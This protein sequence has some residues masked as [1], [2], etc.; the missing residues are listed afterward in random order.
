MKNTSLTTKLTL[1]S[2]TTFI[3]LALIGFIGFSAITNLSNSTDSLYNDSVKQINTLRKIQANDSTIITDIFEMATS[4]S[5]DTDRANGIKEEIATLQ[6]TNTELLKEFTDSLDTKNSVYNTYTE[7]LTTYLD[8]K[9]HALDLINQGKYTDAHMY[10]LSNISIEDDYNIAREEL[11]NDNVQRS[12]QIYQDSKFVKRITSIVIISSIT[13]IIII[14]IILSNTVGKS[15]KDTVVLLINGL[16]AASNGDATVILP[17]D[18]THEAGRMF[19][20]FNQMNSNTRAN[21]ALAQHTI[22][23]VKEISELVVDR[24]SELDKAITSVVQV[25]GSLTNS[26]ESQNSNLYESANAMNEMANGIQNIVEASTTVS[27]MTTNTTTQV[28]NGS[29]VMDETITQMNTIKEVVETTDK[30][31]AGLI[32]RTLTIS[33]SLDAITDIADQTNLLALN[34]SIEAARAGEQ[35]KGFAVVAEEVRKLAD[36]SRASV[37]DITTLLESISKDT[38]NVTKVTEQ[39]KLEVNNGMIKVQQ[40][41]DTFEEIK[42]SIET[43]AVEI[44]NVSSTT[45]EISAGIEEVNASIADIRS[46]SEL[47][48]GEAHSTA[49]TMTEQ[50][51]ELEETNKLSVNAQEASTALEGAL[52][53]FTIK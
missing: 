2:I 23:Q 28:N 24:N 9:Q 19:N 22:T 39:G 35:G 14:S 18:Q 6:E 43:V 44:T 38:D 13:I 16:D 25:F 4:G 33:K 31:I 49:T 53:Q 34:A 30:V 29:V 41:K 51:H 1:L 47:L 3:G 12:E 27:N 32:E 45:E 46:S 21:V 5:T 50:Q 36:Q 10:L 15:I 48:V 8:Y 26:L 17:E 42:Q 40:V 7:N 37:T 20:S 11:V 52:M